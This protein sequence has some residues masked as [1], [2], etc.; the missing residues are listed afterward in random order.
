MTALRV[1]HQ[2]YLRNGAWGGMEKSLVGFL[3]ATQADAEVEN[4][5]IENLRGA[6]PGML[7]ALSCLSAPAREVRRWYGLPLPSSPP[8]LR[9]GHRRSAATKWRV[10]R[11]INWNQVG[12]ADPARLA[13]SLG[14]AA[15]YW[16][17]GS[18]WF[19]QVP[20]PDPEFATAYDLYLANSEASRQ[21]LRQRWKVQGDIQVCTPAL[22]HR[23]DA[24]VPRTLKADR[25]VR[26]GFAARLRA[27]KGGVL[28]VHAL[29]ALVDRGID[30]EL[31]V[32]GEGPDL[33]A[34]QAQAE[35]LGLGSRV[36]FAGWVASMDDWFGDIDLMLHPA[37]REPYGISC[38]EALSRG[39]PVV[40]TRVDGLSE[41]I[42]HGVDGLCVTPTLALTA[43]DA[44]GGDRNDVY[45]LVYRPE[46]GSIAEPGL[47]DPEALADAVMQIVGDASRY[48]AFSAAACATVDGRFSYASHLQRLKSLLRGARAR[49]DAASSPLPT[50]APVA[51]PIR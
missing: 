20:R 21:M 24:A 1:L 12:D 11:V 10:N 48:A 9:R 19:T 15:V 43:F 13:H 30:A 3:A 50:T 16:E 45:P 44:L 33:Q 26:L 40:A 29:R 34:M 14:A 36:R 27:F 4:F 7:D 49:S 8:A 23:L 41:V 5:L 2:A 6:A 51:K 37:L 28:A 25:P 42:E 22:S 32:A 18:A 38:A 17:R 31:W 35:Y 39:I 47:P 46:R